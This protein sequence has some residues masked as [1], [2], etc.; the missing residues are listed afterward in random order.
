MYH[1]LGMVRKPE[2]KLLP[3]KDGHRCE[4]NFKMDFRDRD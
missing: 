3:G 4:N 1:G 2:R